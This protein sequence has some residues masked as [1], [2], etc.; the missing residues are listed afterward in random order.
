MLYVTASATTGGGGGGGD[1]GSTTGP[2]S[3]AP[4]TPRSI[5]AMATLAVFVVSLW[6]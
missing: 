5:W 6:L 4:Q 2:S 1:N 3:D